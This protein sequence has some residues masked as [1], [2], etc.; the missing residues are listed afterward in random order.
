M[1]FVQGLPQGVYVG[2]THIQH[3]QALP[4]AQPE[5]AGFNL[6]LHVNDDPHRVQQHRMTLLDEFSQFGVNKI[7][8]MTQT[9]STICHTINDEITFR[10]FA[11]HRRTRS[12]PSK[13][14]MSRRNIL[15]Q[16]SPV[17]NNC[18]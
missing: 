5:L 9:H 6:A 2:Q 7:T 11:F 15:Y 13:L 12:L 17:S 1:Q 3:D 16:C 8:W 4:S 14:S 18:G 10:S